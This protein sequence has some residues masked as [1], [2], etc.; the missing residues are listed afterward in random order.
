MSRLS[1]AARRIRLRHPGAP[2]P[3]QER[4]ATWLELF[5][6]LAFVLALLG[7]TA[8]LGN[9]ASPTM[10]QLGA[11]LGIYGL[12]QWS[13]LGQSFYDTRYDPDDTTHRLLVLTATIGAGA[14][15]IGVMQV[16]TGLLLPV[17]YLIVRGCLLVM[18]L[19]VLTAD[20]SARDLVTVYGV[21]FGSGWLLWAA[22]LAAPAA[23]RPVFWVT[24]LVI[25]LLTPRLGR[26][27]LNRHP[28]HTTHL[29]ERLGQFTIILLGATLT[30]LRDAVPGA[31][32]PLR[33]LIAAV[34]AFLLPVSIWWIYTTYV[35]SGL[36]VPHLGGGQNY[37]YLHSPAGAAILFLGWSLGAV[38]HQVKLS[39]PVPLTARLVLGGSIVVW[40]LCGMGLQRFALGRLAR[41]RM[42]LGLCGIVPTVVVTVTVTD[43]G[44]LLALTAAI[45]VG[46]A[47]TV[48]PEIV[49]VRDHR[50]GNGTP[51]PAV[52]GAPGS[53]APQDPSR[54][55]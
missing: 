6:D 18:Y 8:R 35:T 49:E 34:V 52:S 1:W 4:H 21:G 39:L 26:R 14:I 41:R 2:D 36:A 25:E 29:P 24:A 22:S 17:G 9:T 47:A 51:A 54:R 33:V 48:S 31:H 30:D 23:A 19:R 46:Y 7:V 12:V 37:A 43:P 45:L 50:S 10:V 38:V 13:W 55:P 32:P 20:R 44:L 16:P 42:L 15:T 3:N 27:W 53:A 40:M 5:F 11:S 28:V